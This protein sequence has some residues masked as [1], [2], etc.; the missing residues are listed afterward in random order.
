MSEPAAEILRKHFRARYGFSLGDRTPSEI[1]LVVRTTPPL[2]DE[3][4]FEVRGRGPDGETTSVLVTRSEMR[5]T[6]RRGR[7]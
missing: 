2:E 3:L 4:A 7:S 5:S 6:V 1:L